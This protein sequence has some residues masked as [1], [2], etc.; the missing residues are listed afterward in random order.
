[1]RASRKPACT[2]YLVR[3]EWWLDGRKQRG[4]SITSGG[5]R[6]EAEARFVR[7]NPHVRVVEV[8]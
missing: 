7:R 2:H 3:Y 4:H 8:K 1:M 5:T 6:A